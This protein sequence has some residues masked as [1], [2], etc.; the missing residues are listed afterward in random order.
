MLIGLLCGSLHYKPSLRESEGRAALV[1]YGHGT[2]G[3]L[4]FPM[5]Q[6]KIQAGATASPYV[7]IEI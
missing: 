3:D 6:E 4:S 1:P 5:I 2:C 7:H